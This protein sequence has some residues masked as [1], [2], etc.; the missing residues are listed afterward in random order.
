MDHLMDT[1]EEH[2]HD[3]YSDMKNLLNEKNTHEV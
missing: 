2:R 1:A 3:I